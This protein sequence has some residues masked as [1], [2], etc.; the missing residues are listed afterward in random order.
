MVASALH[1]EIF[2]SLVFS[3]LRQLFDYKPTITG[4]T[5]KIY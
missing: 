4:V 3:F 1:S 5:I 2:F